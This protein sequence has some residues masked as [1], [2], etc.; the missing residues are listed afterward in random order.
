[1]TQ[2]KFKIRRGDMVQVITGKE[3]GARG[4]VLKILT[5][6]D[7]V[8]VKGV[9]MMTSFKKQSAQN[10]EGMHKKEASMHISNVALLNIETDSP[11]KVGY[12]VDADGKKERFFKNNSASV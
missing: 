8:I 2:K 12:R 11:S 6:K 3:K 4:E 7:R 9:K 1:M 5:E 10:P